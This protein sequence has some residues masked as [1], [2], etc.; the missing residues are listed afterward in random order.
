MTTIHERDHQTSVWQHMPR[1]GSAVQAGNACPKAHTTNAGALSGQKVQN[2]MR[3]H[4]RWS[5]RESKSGPCG[6]DVHGPADDGGFPR[7]IPTRSA[8]HGDR[9]N[10]ALVGRRPFEIL[11]L[12]ELSMLK[13][14]IRL[15]RDPIMLYCGHCKWYCVFLKHSEAGGHTSKQGGLASKAGKAGTQGRRAGTQGRPAPRPAGRRQHFTCS[16]NSRRDGQTEKVCAVYASLV[17]IR[18]ATN[19]IRPREHGHTRTRTRAHARPDARR[20]P[21]PFYVGIF[22]ERLT[23][24]KKRH[25]Q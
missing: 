9:L 11:P 16:K 4:F 23:F 10:L 3:Y 6:P 17:P 22:F 7:R 8:P 19:T 21:R 1:N 25:L 12:G 5:P 13:S 24:S 15:R 2:K 18:R 20:R 14:G